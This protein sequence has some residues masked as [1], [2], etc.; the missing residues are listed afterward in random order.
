MY[1]LQM[2]LLFLIATP[3]LLVN[4][5]DISFLSFSAGESLSDDNI[6]GADPYRMTKGWLFLFAGVLISLFGIVFESIGDRQLA[7]FMKIKKPGQIF[8]S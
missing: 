8:T 7:S 1:I 4:L 5:G 2:I 6:S 3:I